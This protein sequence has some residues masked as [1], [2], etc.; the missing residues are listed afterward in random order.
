V[1]VITRTF[2]GSPGA[3]KAAV[4]PVNRLVS[5]LNAAGYGCALSRHDFRPGTF[6]IEGDTQRGFGVTWQ[7]LQGLREV[8]A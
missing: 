1:S 4:E 5:Q 8:A 7:R 3:P 2:K 6:T